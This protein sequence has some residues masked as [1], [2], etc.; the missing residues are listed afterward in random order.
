MIIK[1]FKNIHVVAFLAIVLVIGLYYLQTDL[2][3]GFEDNTYDLRVNA[4]RTSPGDHPGIA[5][6]A[7]DEKTIAELGRFPFSRIHYATLLDAATSAGAKA[8]LFDAFFPEVQSKAADD[9]F[10]AAMKRSGRVTLACVFEF[11]EDGSVAGLTANI[12]VLQDAA[13]NIAHIN[14][15]PDSDG[16]V[17]WTK[18]SIDYQGKRYP[19][20]GLVGAAEL[21]GTDAFEIGGHSILLGPRRIPIDSEQRMLINYAGPPGT[22][23][24]FS[25]ADVAKGRVPAEK[26]KDRVLFVGATALGIYD[27]RITPFSNNTPGIEVN[28]G[29]ADNI[30]TGDFIRRD[31]LEKIIDLAL[32]I[33]LGIAAALVT[34]NLRHIVSLPLVAILIASHVALCCFL[35]MAGRWISIVYPVLSILLTSA[36]AAYLRF[37]VVDRQAREIRSMFSSYVSKRVVDVLVKNPEMARIGGET[38]EL[39]ILFADVQNY[40]TYSEKRSPADVVRILNDYL[41]AMTDII[42]KYD[43]TLDKFLGDGIMAYWNA[44]LIQKNHAELAVRCALEMMAGMGPLQKKWLSAG[45]EPI[46]WGIGLNTGEVIVGN[47]GAV[48]KKMEYTAIGDSVNLTYRIQ[49]ESRDAHCAVMTRSLYERVKDIV[50]AEPLG[51]VMVK[52][53]RIPIEIFALKGLQ[54]KTAAT[55]KSGTPDH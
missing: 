9:A 33:L 8:V 29:I 39:T 18:P 19:S 25:F 41:A 50:T 45:D 5:M 23:E 52:G 13:R 11:A 20:L 36:I 49:N 24:R 55:E 6:I 46:T 31:A 44:P 53:K 26:L 1:K 14:V 28:A 30:T 2:L 3:E 4:L 42:I 37:F 47:I 32:I 7:I 10:A 48:G 54:P 17:R 12:P 38:R 21:L 35:F 16:V 15:F 51:S 43:G 40:T 34:W 27:M 22:Y